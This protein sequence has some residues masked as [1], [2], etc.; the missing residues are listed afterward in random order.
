MINNDKLFSRKSAPA[1]TAR[2]VEAIIGCKWSITVYHLLD[3]GINRIPYIVLATGF[4]SVIYTSLGG[5]GAVVVTDFLQTVLL[6]GGALLVVVMIS[7][8]LGGFSWFPTSWQ[9]GWDVQPLFS[10]DPRVRVT[11]LGGILTAVIWNVCTAGGDQVAVQRFMATG[12][13]RAAQRSYLAKICVS[14]GVSVALALVGFSLL[15]YFT[16]RPEALPAGM[17]LATDGDKIFPFFVAYHL[18]PGQTMKLL[19]RFAR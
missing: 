17:S 10:P 9:S 16:Q 6:L 1:K 12:N 4:V 7:I 5:L 13:A 18:P 8:S 15:G 3:N 2:M 14:G 19:K 11:I